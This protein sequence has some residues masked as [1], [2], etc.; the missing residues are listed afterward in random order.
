MANFVDRVVLH[1]IG[2]NGGHGVASIHRE[3]FKP[4]AGPDGGNG[5]NGGSVRLVVDPSTT[6]LLGYH[7]L[8]HRKAEN[9]AGGAGDYRDGAHGADLVLPVPDGTV[10]KDMDGNVLADL[11]GVGAEYVAAAGGRGGLGN[12]SLASAK[13]KAP[14]FALLGEPG[15]EQDIVLDVLL[16]IYG[17]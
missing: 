1:A 14:G 9:G 6:T 13:R 12:K 11:I 4:L 10:V 5:G 2:G 16:S 7:H 17:V 15:E 8:P 3:K